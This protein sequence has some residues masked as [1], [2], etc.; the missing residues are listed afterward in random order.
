MSKSFKDLGLHRWLAGIVAA[1]LDAMLKAVPAVPLISRCATLSTRPHRISIRMRTE[2][3]LLNG[4]PRPTE[5]LRTRGENL[6]ARHSRE[7]R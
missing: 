6:G 4:R 3:P 7:G 1:S 2:S 5:N